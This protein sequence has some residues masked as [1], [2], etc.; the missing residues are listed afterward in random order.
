MSYNKVA[1]GENP[2]QDINVIIE[3]A[4]H[5]A[6]VKYEI[7]KDTDLITVDR[8]MPVSM[9]YPANYGYIPS[10][11]SEDGDPLDVLVVA[12]TPV[13]PGSVVRSR[14][15]GILNME[16][17]AGQDAKIIA[18][19]HPKLTVAYDDIEDIHQLP[20]LLRQQIEHFFENYK[21]LEKGKWV[22]IDQWADKAAALKAIEKSLQK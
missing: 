4:A 8:F 10:T 21:K 22:K 17:E 16:D 1:A 18:C 19:A 2:P 15:I 3:I 7:D 14:P 12:P 13:M 6:P 5:S 20:S 9:A 11:M